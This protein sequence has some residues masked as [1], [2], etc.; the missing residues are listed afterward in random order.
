MPVVSKSSRFPS[1]RP[2]PVRQERMRGLCE[3]GSGT[4]VRSTLR[5]V[6]AMVPDPFSHRQIEFAAARFSGRCDHDEPMDWRHTGRM[7]PGG[8]PGPGPRAA[9]ADELR[10]D[11]QRR[12]HPRT[13]GPA[14]CTGGTVQR[15]QP[16]GQH[17]QCVRLRSALCPVLPPRLR[18]LCLPGLVVQE[19][20]ATRTDCH[21]QHQHCRH[22]NV[23][24]GCQIRP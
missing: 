6:P 18:G 5:A 15:P 11:R 7:L 9:R 1:V 8:D 13:D 21:Q 20:K 4:I 24:L 3:K 12:G 10:H 14:L 22:G 19:P 16:A 2:I 17:P 23:R